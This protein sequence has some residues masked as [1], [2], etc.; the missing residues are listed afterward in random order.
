MFGI[1]IF[2]HDISDNSKSVSL[3]AL[4]FYTISLNRLHTEKRLGSRL[5]HNS[6]D[7]YL[8]SSSGLL[9]IPCQ[10]LPEFLKMTYQHYIM[11]FCWH[12]SRDCYVRSGREF[13]FTT[14]KVFSCIRTLSVM[15][16]QC[17]G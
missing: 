7:L 6:T 2:C 10:Q 5:H 11:Y 14:A 17:I 9:K 16:P 3:N 15:G 8:Y 4:K 13:S 12:N 1:D